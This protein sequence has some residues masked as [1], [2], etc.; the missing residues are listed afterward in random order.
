MNSVMMKGMLVR[1]FTRFALLVSL[2]LVLACQ[3]LIS[4]KKLTDQGVL[5]PFLKNTPNECYYLD[6]FMPVP[7][8]M[9]T[10]KS[11]S[12]S[13][14]YYT[15]NAASYKDWQEKQII[16]SFYSKDSRCWSL[17]EEYYVLD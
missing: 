2:H 10:G 7:N 8:N 4:T 1:I 11:G 5:L 9:V 14:R 16:L 15:Y 6:D 13:L 17:F 12:L 3:L